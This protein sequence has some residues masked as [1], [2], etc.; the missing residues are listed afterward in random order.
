MKV[1]EEKTPTQKLEAEF[2]DVHVFLHYTH[3]LIPEKLTRR[4]SHTDL[5]GR[6]VDTPL[7][8][9]ARTTYITSSSL[10][11]MKGASFG[12]AER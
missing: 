2:D 10:F 1:K 3:S 9:G 4:I 6:E 8:E 11:A 12:W 7:H 5:A